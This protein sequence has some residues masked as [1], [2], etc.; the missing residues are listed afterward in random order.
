MLTGLSAAQVTAQSAPDAGQL[1]Q[2]QRAKPAEMP[3][4][5]AG[6]ELVPVPQTLAVTA[7]TTITVKSF[8]FQ[9]NALLSE[10]QLQRVVTPYLDRKLDFKELQEVTTQVAKRYMAEGRL[11][12][13]FLPAQD[14]TNGA[15]T[16]QI[17]EARYGG[18]Q[19]EQNGKRLAADQARAMVDA[20][21]VR[22]EALDLVA[23]DRALLLV[24]DLPG[25][26]AS[27][28]LVPGAAPRET[29]VAVSLRDQD[30]LTGQV[31]AD[32]AG[33]RS[34]GA[35]RL[36]ASLALN[37]ALGVG[38]QFAAQA[39]QSQGSTFVRLGATT[40]VG[41]QGV[42]VG[43]NASALRYRLV[44]SDFEALKARGTASSMGLEASYPLIRSRDRNVLLQAGADTKRF[45]NKANGAEVSDYKSRA[46]TVAA[47][48]N[49]FDD[50]GGGGV[51]SGYFGVQM[52]RLD[53]GGSPS[54]AYDAAGPRTDGSF[55]KVRY[56]VARTQTVSGDWSVYGALQ[57]QWA[58]KN[59]DSSERFYLG[60]PQGVRAYPVSEAG[61]AS[62]QLVNVELRWRLGA[63]WRASG[64]VD[65]G[66]LTTYVDGNFP[67]APSP[68]SYSLKGAGFSVDYASPAGL[69]ASFVLARRL[70]DNPNAD[71]RGRDQDGSLERNRFWL[72]VSQQF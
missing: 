10:S 30:V 44:G 38:D 65:W 7:G 58:S 36:H 67:G 66:H 49:Q 72:L 19:V 39:S 2:N 62:G 22:G 29:A 21:Q 37:S 26:K 69:E 23:L 53:L 25:V 43:L 48:A 8:R 61:G 34:T 71:V 13:A 6:T 56:Q 50:F 64:F 52:G 5:A 14:V 15:V 35:A 68:N 31:A 70:G 11:A 32:N 57:G 18:V 46:L 16:I 41:V 51:S 63:G 55:R 60:G 20:G 45:T 1:L 59:L 42:R 12:R 47:V 40:P 24:G 3:R 9:G 17:L 54:L 27:A 33:T 4:K 28:S